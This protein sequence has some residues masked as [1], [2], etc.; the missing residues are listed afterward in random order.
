MVLQ[1][2]QAR[3][4]AARGSRSRFGEIRS[5]VRC[6]PVLRGISTGPT[7]AADTR[8]AGFGDGTLA[9]GKTRRTRCVSIYAY[10]MRTAELVRRVRGDAALS[11]RE[12]ASR[13]NLAVSTIHR[14]EQG[15]LHPTVDTLEKLVRATG[16]RLAL[17]VP[18]DYA[19]SVLGLGLAI[20]ADLVAADPS[21]IV[22]KSAEL[23][24]R[25]HTSDLSE[26]RRMLAAEP[27]STGQ[28]EWDAFL[29]GLGEWLATM[30]GLETPGWASVPA[31]FLGRGWWVTPMASMRAWEYAGTPVSLQRH[32][33][34]L[35]RDSLIN[36]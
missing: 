36:R 12:L 17:E 13:S 5:R 19:A 25:F 7:R 30:G 20:R 31:R 4:T 23:V 10:S 33:V 26:Q 27:P 1:S 22:R 28:V 29:G 15:E 35:H 9:G 18:L 32:G 16:R 2:G 21:A 11:L 3:P 14:I 34:Y 8:A 6:D 24:Y